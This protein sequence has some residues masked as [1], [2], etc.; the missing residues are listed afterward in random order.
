MTKIYLTL[1]QSSHT[2]SSNIWKRPGPKDCVLISLRQLHLRVPEAGLATGLFL[3]NWNK[4]Q[5]G[6]LAPAY[7]SLDY[8]QFDQILQTVKND[9]TGLN[10]VIKVFYKHQFHHWSLYFKQISRFS[11]NFFF[12]SQYRKT[13]MG[14]LCYRKIILVSKNFKDK[15]GITIFGRIFFVSQYRKPSMGTLCVTEKLFWYRKISRIRRV[16]QFSVEYFLSPSTENLRWETFALQ[17]NYSGIEK[18]QG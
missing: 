13:S 17:E 6:W 14:N 5:D 15:K 1:G 4:K 11:I 9:T 7:F 18:F 3:T 8:K 10:L 12:V 16:S 2:V